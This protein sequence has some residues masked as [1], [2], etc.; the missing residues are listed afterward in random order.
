M[1]GHPSSIGAG[2]VG[3][4]AGT[5]AAA[6]GLAPGDVT[7]SLGGHAVTSAAGLRSAIDAYHPRNTASVSCV[8]QS[9]QAHTATVVFTAGP[10][11]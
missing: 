10:V 1:P 9:G 5:P 11:G 8:G 6:V 7:V 4:T 2:I 3:V